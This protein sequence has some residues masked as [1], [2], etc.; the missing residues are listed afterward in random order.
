MS[1]PKKRKPAIN[2]E[3]SHIKPAANVPAPSWE[4]RT[5]TILVGVF[6]VGAFFLYWK[7]P[8]P[9]LAV[10]GVAIVAAVM[11]ID[12]RMGPVR[13]FFWLLLLGTFAALEARAISK[14]RTEQN[15]N[16]AQT[17]DTI[18]GGNSYAF[19][20]LRPLS[21]SPTADNLILPYLIQRGPNP[22]HGLKITIGPLIVDN[23]GFLVNDNLPPRDVA[24][25]ERT[26]LMQ[27]P[28]RFPAKKMMMFT[29][30]Y[31]A[32]NGHW[33]QQVGLRVV[34]GK[35][36]EAIQVRRYSS[37]GTTLKILYEYEDPDFP[38]INGQ[39]DWSSPNS[40]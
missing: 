37:Q 25:D 28:L 34:K 1:K 14:D 20:N 5:F 16:F 36:C 33:S 32:L 10:L 40:Y 17:L 30:Y 3:N 4:G 13:K 38:K 8:V 19:L 21:E 31:D 15:R 24:V 29:V 35:W 27:F 6:S 39:P 22:L 23:H 26:Q 18:T 9:G 11:T 2:S 7:Y 12:L